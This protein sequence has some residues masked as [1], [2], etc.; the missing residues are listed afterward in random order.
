MSV[1]LSERQASERLM[2][3]LEGI[4]ET[5]DRLENPEDG[6]SQNDAVEDAVCRLDALQTI[7]SDTMEHV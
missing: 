3:V 2:V 6:K 5:K 7:L 4:E 1:E